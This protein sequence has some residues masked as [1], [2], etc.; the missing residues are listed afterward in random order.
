MW[1]RSAKKALL[2][3][4]VALV[5]HLLMLLL[6]RNMPEQELSIARAIPDSAKRV[7]LLKPLKEHPKATGAN[8]REAAELLREGSPLDA[9]E[10]A[11]AAESKEPGSE[12][13]QL[14][15]ARICH[16]QRMKRCEEE[17][18]QRA[19]ELSPED[20]RAALLRAD[21]HERDGDVEGALK[22]V[23]EAYRKAPGREGVGVRY[24]RLLSATSRGEEAIKVLET[25]AR[26][27]GKSRLWVEQ[28]LV[29]VAQGRL[30]EGRRLFARAVEED[31]KL[32]PAYYHLG[33]TEYRLGDIEAAEEALREADRLDMTSMRAL[34]A[35]CEIQRRTGRVN[36]MT[37][38][39]MDLERRF[40]EKLGAV[41]SACGTR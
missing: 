6:P 8:L 9:Y 21:F 31:P 11:K 3:C 38:T 26:L 1:N 39:R 18:L 15:L 19:E 5:L 7:T 23:E 24:A 17:S 27:L 2:V 4:L 20:P 34:S 28:G 35:L 16:G 40:P 12:E 33:L 30:E 29:R 37:V 22:A 32:A 14:L 41:Q 36:D 25:Q 13:T 10:L